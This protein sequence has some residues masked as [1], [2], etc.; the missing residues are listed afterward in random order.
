[1]KK[2]EA[3]PSMKKKE[4]LEEAYIERMQAEELA[5]DYDENMYL[6]K[7]EEPERATSLPREDIE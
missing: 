6:A 1:M 2:T 5:I 4:Y 3:T 7:E